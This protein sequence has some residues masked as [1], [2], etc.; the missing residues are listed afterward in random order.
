MST[1]ITQIMDGSFPPFS[2]VRASVF[3]KAPT[4]ETK[5]KHDK[6]TW[7]SED[8]KISATK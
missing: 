7:K 1:L 6:A 2:F 3:I 5:K 8:Q 4:Y